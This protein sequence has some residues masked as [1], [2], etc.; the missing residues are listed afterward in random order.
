MELYLS[1]FPLS[2]LMNDDRPIS[3]SKRHCAY[4]VLDYL[5][6][7]AWSILWTCGFIT[8]CTLSSNYSYYCFKCP[9][10]T[11]DRVYM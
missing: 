8:S 2:Y 9:Q 3:E 4:C 1:G 7:R 11:T 5:E 6:Q 10:M